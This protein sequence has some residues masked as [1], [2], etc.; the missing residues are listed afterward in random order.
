MKKQRD[1]NE[2]MRGI[3]ID[4]MIDVHYRLRLVPR[5]LYLSVNIVDRYLAKVPTLRSHLQV[6]G[7]TALFI[8]AKFEEI[9]PPTCDSFIFM[10]D[11][12]YTEAQVFKMEAFILTEL[13]F[14]LNIPSAH[15]FISRYLENLSA[16]NLTV[17][18]VSNYLLE[19]SLVDYQ[20]LKYP[21]SQ[22]A[23]GALYLACMSLNVEISEETL[24]KSTD[25]SVSDVDPCCK[26][27]CVTLCSSVEAN[28]SAV[29]R[30]YSNPDFGKVAKKIILYNSK[31]V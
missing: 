21:P 22:I 5:A 29:F 12:T 17:I 18:N 3:L 13:D 27:L 23:A 2:K 19:L 30:K 10:T 14:Q 4:W 26:D 6:V 31:F 16:N 7:V 15:D 20:Y 11:Y 1:I 28:K 8:A 24:L 25:Y 9:Y